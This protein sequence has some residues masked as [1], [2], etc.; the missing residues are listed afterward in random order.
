MIMV[1]P[2][3]KLAETVQMRVD[4]NDVIFSSP[5]KKDDFGLVNLTPK[6]KSTLLLQMKKGDFLFIR[7]N[8]K[9]SENEVTVQLN[10]KDFRDAV[11]F[12]N[13]KFSR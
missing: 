8:I 13:S 3:L 5:V 6:Q 2:N 12:Y 4:K 11:A 7:F 9:A 10:L 1:I